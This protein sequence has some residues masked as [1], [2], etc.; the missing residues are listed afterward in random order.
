M[1]TANDRAVTFEQGF[2]AG[3]ALLK[4]YLG[5]YTSERK[6][7]DRTDRHRADAGLFRGQHIPPC[8]QG[9]DRPRARGIPPYP[10]A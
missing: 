8:I 2:E 1:S 10:A 6:Y 3:K 7:L 5:E 9:L 4:D